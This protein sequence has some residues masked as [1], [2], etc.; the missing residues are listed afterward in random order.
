M[1]HPSQATLALHA[2]GDLG[3]FARWR[4]DRHLADCDQCREEVAAYG[5]VR[6]VLPELS[7][8]PEVAWNRLSA[9]MQANI[10]LGLAAGECVR[11]GD[12]PLRRSLFTGVRA[13]VALASVAA[14]LVTGLMIERPMPR[15]NSRNE[16]IVVQRIPN[17]IQVREGGQALQLMHAGAQ[18]Q[19]V[20]YS[21][22]AQG[23]L[24]AR[25]VD[26]ETGNVTFNTVYVEE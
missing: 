8:M 20:I 16:G 22:G 5:D 25:F 26:Q 4:V 15:P 14:L 13:A 6:E 24:R 3:P 18:Q 10:R 1:K 7:E 17:G 11:T 12:V 21:V 9:E 19:Q 2:G 23:S